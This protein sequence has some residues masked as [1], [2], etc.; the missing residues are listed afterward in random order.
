MIRF[1]KSSDRHALENIW[2]NGFH[3]GE[4]TIKD[5]FTKCEGLFECLVY[6][7]GENAVAAMYIFDCAF[8]RSDGEYKSAYLY[9]LSTLPEYR[10][11][12]IMTELVKYAEAYLAEKGYDYI[13]LAP[14][15]N[16]LCGYYERLGFSVCDLKKLADIPS[17][18]IFDMPTEIKLLSVS[19]FYEL[20]K[21]TFTDYVRFEGKTLNFM[22]DFGEMTAIKFDGGYALVDTD[23]DIVRVVEFC[24]EINR[25]LSAVKTKFNGKT[26]RVYLENNALMGETVCRGM[27]KPLGD[28]NS[29]NGV[30]IGLIMD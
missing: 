4:S 26:Y 16:S 30:H 8:C 22:L 29:Q 17:D 11:K 14:S 23:E 3:D 13:F 5:F 7:D 25:V 19:E 18:C 20:R 27:M 10:G 12:G 2:R 9:A 24:G 15:E 21:N 28:T 1:A 6:T